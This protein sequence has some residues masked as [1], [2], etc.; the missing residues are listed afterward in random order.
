MHKTSPELVAIEARLDVPP[1]HGFQHLNKLIQK[2]TQQCNI[3]S[4]ISCMIMGK[5]SVTVKFQVPTASIPILEKRI[6]DSEQFFYNMKVSLVKILEKTVFET[7]SDKKSLLK[8]LHLSL[9][10]C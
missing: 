6:A 1:D 10:H 8:V 4:S 3:E 7:D 2:F 5:N 9:C